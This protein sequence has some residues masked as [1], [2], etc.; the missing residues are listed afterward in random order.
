MDG[1]SYPDLFDR[2][3][4]SSEMAKIL[5]VDDSKF[6]RKCVSGML[7]NLGHLVSEAEDGQKGLQMLEAAKPDLIIT[8]LLMPVMDG[9]SL[10]RGLNEKKCSVP[11]VVVSADIQESTKKECLKLG[12]KAFLNKPITSADL[13]A[14]VNHLV[15]PATEE[16]SP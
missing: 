3:A 2:Y 11:T 1:V 6:Q 7:T 8:D 10:L 15:R 12:A 9:L 4:R 14:M 16:K 13:E 5:L